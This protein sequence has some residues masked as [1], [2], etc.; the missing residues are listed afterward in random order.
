MNGANV[1]LRRKQLKKTNKKTEQFCQ[2]ISRGI[3]GKRFSVE[4]I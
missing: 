2:A 1:I 4:K 3:F